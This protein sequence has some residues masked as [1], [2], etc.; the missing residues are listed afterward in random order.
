MCLIFNCV[1]DVD[2]IYDRDQDDLC[3]HHQYDNYTITN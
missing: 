2:Y 3:H 1:I